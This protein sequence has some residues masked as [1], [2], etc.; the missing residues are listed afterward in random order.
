MLKGFEKYTAKLS[1][2]EKKIARKLWRLL[3]DSPEFITNI[4]IQAA[5]SQQGITTSAPRVRQMIN[6]MH[7]KG[8]LPNLIASSRGY[9]FARS[10][11][12]LAN[13]A[14]SLQGRVMAIEARRQRTILDLKHWKK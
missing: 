5:L 6:W 14:E 4:E 7:I 8:Y 10:L 13:Y 11:Q 3:H 12:E 9:S 2:D 1:E